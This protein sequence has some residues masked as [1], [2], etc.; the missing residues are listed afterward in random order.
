[1]D[2]VPY[3]LPTSCLDCSPLSPCHL[4]RLPAAELMT[5]LQQLMTYETTR[6]ADC[7]FRRERIILTSDE[8]VT[9]S[10]WR[11]LDAVSMATHVNK[12]VARLYRL[13]PWLIRTENVTRRLT[14]NQF[15]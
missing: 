8:T 2:H 4:D 1:M 12:D 15:I 14:S 7:S 10:R 13:Y 6:E 9:S 11:S 5:T 3:S